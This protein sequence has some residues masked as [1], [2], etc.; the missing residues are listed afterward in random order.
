MALTYKEGTRKED[1]KPFEIVSVDVDATCLSQVSLTETQIKAVNE[2][3]LT[4]RVVY[5]LNKII[6]TIF[7][8]RN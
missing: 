5:P 1:E 2:F 6:N 4:E 3:I 8:N 7:I